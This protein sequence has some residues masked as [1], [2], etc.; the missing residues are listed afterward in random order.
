MMKNI[1]MQKPLSSISESNSELQSAKE[2]S[3]LKVTR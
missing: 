1:G 2:D 3:A